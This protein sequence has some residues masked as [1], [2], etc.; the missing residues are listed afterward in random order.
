MPRID[1]DTMMVVLMGGL[2]TAIPWAVIHLAC[3]PRLG[4]S[5][6]ACRIRNAIDIAATIIFPGG[7]MVVAAAAIVLWAWQGFPA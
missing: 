4:E 5:D 7:S 3:Y 2:V 1:I 6:R